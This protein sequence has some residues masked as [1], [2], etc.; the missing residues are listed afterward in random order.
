MLKRKTEEA[1]AARRRLRELSAKSGAAAR[2][3]RV[4][5]SATLAK[6]D[7]KTETARREWVEKELEMEN[8][9]RDGRGVPACSR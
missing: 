8:Q 1:E 5:M 6:E 4:D 7:H 2:K 3:P 9:V